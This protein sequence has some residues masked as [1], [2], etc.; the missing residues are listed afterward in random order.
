MATRK[1]PA[2]REQAPE[3]ARQRGGAPAAEAGPAKPAGG[4]AGTGELVDM[5]QAIAMLGTT[6]PTFYRWLRGGRLRGLKA[7]RQWRFERAEVERFLR[8]EAPRV[9]LPVS[10]APLVEKLAARAAKAGVRDLPAAG[11]AGPERAVD[12][13]VRLGVALRASDIHVE[14]LT[15]APGRET[16]GV[17][18]YRIDGALHPAA[19]FDLRLLP[20]IAERFK[21]LA[22]CDVREK[23]MPQDGRI[24]L[25]IGDRKLDL[26]VCFV[27]PV[28]GE[29]VTVRLL[30]PAAA[31]LNLANIDY[32]PADRERLLRGIRAPWGLVALTGPTGSG[33]TTVLYACLNEISGPDVKTMSLEDPVEFLLPWVTQI[34]VRPAHGL[35]FSQGLR[36][37]LRSDPD[38]ILVGEIRDRE[39]LLVCQQAALTG[40]LVMT[41]L[42]TDE[43]VSALK[44][45]VE[46]G[47][48]PFVVAESMRLVA[49]QRLVRKLCPK[50]SR[51]EVPSAEALRRAAE[52]AR[53]GGLGWEALRP[54]FRTRVGCDGCGG[55]GFRG[56]T[57]VTEVLEMTPE[58]GRALREGADA[59]RLRALAVGQGMTTMAADGIRRAAAGQVALHEVLQMLGVR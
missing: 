48:E 5:E 19:E 57:V 25:D 35:S 54:E 4:A 36:S 24:L 23:R 42:H 9:E 22:A 40:H 28:M 47:S 18:R 31:L 41:T 16:V 30:D 34:A 7:G 45:M 32:A 3:D 27:G 51:Q 46:I 17:V 14:P 26:R 6:R 55:T 33:K 59:D 15:T 39:T 29:A 13:I 49:A 44:R 1:T 11:D 52:L 8:G 10:I 50:C 56:R 12:L 20:A 43:A 37:V 53:G 2:R 21:S 38:V 58:I